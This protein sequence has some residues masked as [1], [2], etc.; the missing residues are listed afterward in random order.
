MKVLVLTLLLAGAFAV[1]LRKSR[2]LRGLNKIVGGEPA[3]PGEFPYQAS[4]QDTS[5]GIPFHFCGASIYQER[6]L[7]TAGHCVYGEDYNYPKHLQI[8][9]G[10][11]NLKVHEGNEQVL[12]VTRIYMHEHYDHDKIINDIAL[13]KIKSELTW[14]SY[15]E[16]ILLETSTATGDCQVTGWGSFSEGGDTPEDILHKVTVPI[17]SDE[18]CKEAYADGQ[19]LDTMIC[20]GGEGGKDSCQGDSGGPLNCGGHL[21]GVISWRYGCAR[22]GYPGVYTE[23]SHYVDWIHSQVG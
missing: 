20:A 21:A 17:I 22:P 6:I 19:V 18:K 11:H 9:A 5:W 12:P 13:L 1:P 2:L 15:V 23:V 10:E 8:V 4:L 3:T 16:P 14:D 7:I